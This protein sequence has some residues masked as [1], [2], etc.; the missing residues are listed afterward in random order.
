MHNLSGILFSVQTVAG[1]GWRWNGPNLTS[2]LRIGKFSV[3]QKVSSDLFVEFW[4]F[5]S[6]NLPSPLVLYHENS[7][8]HSNFSLSLHSANPSARTARKLAYRNVTGWRVLAALA[9][10]R[11]LIHSTKILWQYQ[12]LRCFITL[13]PITGESS[14][15]FWP[16]WTL[17]PKLIPWLLQ[18]WTT[19]PQYH[20]IST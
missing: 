11:G 17:Y 3:E 15:V 12:V 13:I 19:S 2:A 18:T 16:L 6:V 14:T 5:L 10:D 20:S 9:E 1:A 8:T 4:T 7:A